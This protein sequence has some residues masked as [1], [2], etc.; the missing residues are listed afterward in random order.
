MPGYS[1]WN[2][3]LLFDEDEEEEIW[4]NGTRNYWNE[5][6]INSLNCKT[7]YLYRKK[8]QFSCYPLIEIDKLDRSEKNHENIFHDSFYFSILKKKNFVSQIQF[9]LS[10]ANTSLF[11]TFL[12]RLLTIYSTLRISRKVIPAIEQLRSRTGGIVFTTIQRDSWPEARL[13]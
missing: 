11:S 8:Y 7:S 10:I 1:D 12:S 13:N 3:I 2:R 5:E 9:R 6:I 4:R